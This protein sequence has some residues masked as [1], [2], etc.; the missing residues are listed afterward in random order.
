MIAGKR[1]E[2]K[3]VEFVLESHEAIEQAVVIPETD[4]AGMS[5]LVAHVVASPQSKSENLLQ[6]SVIHEYLQRQLPDYKIPDYFVQL[7]ELPL[8]PN[9]KVNKH[10][11]PIVLKEANRS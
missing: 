5:Y 11:L 7:E 3:E 9:G 2:P 10:A 8:T 6:A 4:E 1:V